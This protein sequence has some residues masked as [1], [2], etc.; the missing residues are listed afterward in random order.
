MLTA[1]LLTIAL[2]QMAANPITGTEARKHIGEEA[3]V[4]GVVA[5]TRYLDTTPNRATFLNFDRPN[6]DQTFTAVIFGDARDKFDRPEVRY[7]DKQ[8]CVTGRIAD[9]RGTP[10][11]VVT[12]PGQIK[13]GPPTPARIHSSEVA[14]YIGAE[15]SVCGFVAST[16]YDTAAD[17]KPTLLAFD[18][19]FPDQTFTA[20]IY[21]DVRKKF[22]APG[23]RYLHRNVCV[24]GRV[25][26]LQTAIR[27]VLTDPKQIAFLR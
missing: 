1:H 4:C 6:P 15:L 24:T 19:P 8:I 3:T 16:R 11:I 23:L 12:E 7:K 5:S 18:K 13:E 17:G 27:M 25:E 20:V 2:T 21:D 14:G 10:Q 9:F 22:G 26:K